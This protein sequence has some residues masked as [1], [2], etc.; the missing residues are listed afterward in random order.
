MVVGLLAGFLLPSSIET[1][2]FLTPEER[3][4]AAQRLKDDRPSGNAASEEFSWVA[5]CRAIL[6]VQVSQDTLSRSISL[7][8]R[9]LTIPLLDVAVRS[10]LLCYSL[11]SVFLRALRSKH[12]SCNILF[13]LTS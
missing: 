6:S 11:R 10:C 5:V 8:L 12:R 1:A 13:I 7:L 4:F 9:M 2:S 3:L